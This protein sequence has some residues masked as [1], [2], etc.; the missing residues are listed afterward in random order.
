[1][2]E[3]MVHFVSKKTINPTNNL[4]ILI[5]S[6]ISTFVCVETHFSFASSGNH[7][8]STSNLEEL[9]SRERFPFFKCYGCV[10]VLNHG[11]FCI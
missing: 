1:M 8:I 9:I 10:Y 2:R 11:S 3:M 6:K 4:K 5:L 7:Q